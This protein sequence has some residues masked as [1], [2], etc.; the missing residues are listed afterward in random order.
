MGGAYLEGEGM[1]VGPQAAVQVHFGRE[2]KERTVVVTVIFVLV[3][4][5]CSFVFV[6]C[7]VGLV[8]AK[9]A[10]TTGLVALAGKVGRASAEM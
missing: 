1:G 2:V 3:V 6:G 9:R 4:V 5:G 10:M 8:S 7:I